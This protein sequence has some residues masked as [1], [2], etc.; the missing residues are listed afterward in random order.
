MRL[1]DRLSPLK[2]LAGLLLA[3]G[4]LVGLIAGHLAVTAPSEDGRERDRDVAWDALPVPGAVEAAR[5]DRPPRRLARRL[6]E[7][8]LFGNAAD[9]LD[10]LAA[11]ADSESEDENAG[12]ETGVPAFPAILAA[13]YLDREP[14]VYLRRADGSIEARREGSRT[15]SGW[16]ILEISLERVRA[17]YGEKATRSFPVFARK[18]GETPGSQ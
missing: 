15:E 7:S 13:A 6:L 18:T 10:R 5:S 4:G 3:L 1:P 2:A 12:E 9:T 17:R 14:V 8:G 11:T 16:Q